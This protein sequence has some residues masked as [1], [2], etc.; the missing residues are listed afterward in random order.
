[1]FFFEQQP[2]VHLSFRSSSVWLRSSCRNQLKWVTDVELIHLLPELELLKAHG[3]KWEKWGPEEIWG[4]KGIWLPL[5]LLQFKAGRQRWWRGETSLQTV[6]TP[7]FLFPSQLQWCLEIISFLPLAGPEM[8]CNSQ[9]E[10]SR[11][12]LVSAQPF[13]AI[14]S[15]SPNIYVEKSPAAAYTQ[16]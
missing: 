15:S 6:L 1:M 4:K 11:E 14:L 7:A 2:C 3:G 16:T 8:L 10:N 9:E 5:P 12:W 13:N